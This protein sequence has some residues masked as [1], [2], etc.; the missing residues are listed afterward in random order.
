MYEQ[1]DQTQLLEQI[2]QI[3]KSKNWYALTESNRFVWEKSVEL[4]AGMVSKE[5]SHIEPQQIKEI[6]ENSFDAEALSKVGSEYFIDCLLKIDPNLTIWS[7]GDPDWQQ[8]KA[9]KTGLLNRSNLKTEFIN[10]D[11]TTKLKDLILSLTNESEDKICILIID[12][13][14]KNLN[15]AINLQE[16]IADEDAIIRTFQL[17]LQNTETNPT[18]CLAFIATIPEKNIRIIVDMDGVL[19]DTNRILA[20]TVSQKLAKILEN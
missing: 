18:A 20:E 6:I 13:K 11:K 15:C 16:Q 14:V 10:K 9:N 3:I 2:K 5:I 4:M 7:E 8:L 1:L 12:D 17:N 19:V